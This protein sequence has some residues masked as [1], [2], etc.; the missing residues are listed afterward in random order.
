MARDALLEIGTEEIPASYIGPATAQMAE[1][2][3]KFLSA[4]GL[5]CGQIATYATPRRLTVHLKEVCDK[6][7]ERHEEFMGPSLK[8]GKDAD[9]NFTQAARGFAAKFG[10]DPAK[11]AVKKTE[12]GEYLCVTK[13]IAGEK[14]EI[15]LKELF[16]GMIGKIYFP[17]TMIWEETAFKFAR[18]IRSITAFYGDK[19]LKISAAGVKSS[20]WCGGLHTASKRKIIIPSAEKYYG[21]LKNNCIIAA[22]E[23]RR[24][25][26][27]K[28]IEGAAKRAKGAVI[29]DEQLLDEVVCLVEHPVAVLGKFS[30]NYLKIPSEVLITCMKKK[31]KYFPLEDDKGKLMNYFIGIRNGISENQEVVKEGY[32]RVLEAR[33]S[34]AEFFFHKDTQKPLAEKVE[35]L[36]GV[37]LHAKLGTVHDKIL[38]IGELAGFIKAGTAGVFE[39]SDAE[40]KEAVNLSKADLVT[41]MVFEYPELQG[42]MGRIYAAQDELSKEV[43]RGIEEHYWPISG[44]SKL[45]VSDAGCIV[46]IADKIDTLAADFS[47]GLVPSG[48]Q[49]PYGLRRMAT[50]VLRIIVKKKLN[51]SLGELVEKAFGVLPENIRN[52]V[53]AKA[54]LLEFMKQRLENML[55]AQGFKFDEVRSVLATGFDDINDVQRRLEALKKMRQEADF[56]ALAAAFK[57]ASNILKQAQKMSIAVPSE[58]SRELMK[59]EAESALYSS[60]VRIR[61]EIIS[62]IENKEY[63]AVMQKMVSLKPDVDK[64]FDKVMVM[65]DDA[66]LKANRLAILQF[67]VGLFSNL[68]DFSLLQQ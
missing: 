67:T 60:V 59:E 25:I 41:E 23:E 56:A 40:L 10:M 22:R 30:E 11:L 54:Q 9:G 2:T 63:A 48:S 58:V 53:S 1:L 28:I 38:R 52:S 50:G 51:I 37:V 33:L 39:I 17:K 8:V 43:S 19:V 55:E 3:A 18:P 20:N 64:F 36:K 5:A 12:K 15:I 61:E 16:Q 29:E 7:R 65:A 14:A 13:K 46:S 34:D 32:E 24:D 68:L 27:N 62:L 44:D 31:Q 47:I 35:K 66:D 4:R 26:L 57:R 21:T 6:T 49:D 42:I 45:P